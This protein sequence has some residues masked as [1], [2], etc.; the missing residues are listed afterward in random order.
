MSENVSTKKVICFGEVLWDN[1][2]E[3]RRVGGAPLNVCY[4]LNKNGVPSQVV[5]QI[6]DDADGRDLSDAINTLQVDTRFVKSTPHHPTSRVEVH[7]FEDGQVTYDIIEHVAWDYIPYDPEV[8]AAIGQA[9]ALVF[10][11]LAARN[12]I[13]KAT[14]NRYLDGAT[15]AVLD[16]NLRQP[17]YSP[18]LIKDLLS[19][20]HVLKINAE[21]LDALAQWM[22]LEKYDEGDRLTRLLHAYPNIGEIL[23]TKGVRGARYHSRDTQLSVA[24]LKVDS[25]STVG[26]GDSFLAAFLARRMAG[27]P[28]DE[29]MDHAVVL[30]AFVSTHHGACPDYTEALLNAFKQK[31]QP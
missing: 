25:V 12:P 31:N 9:D 13:S 24:A 2:P 21:E 23:L 3:G 27:H 10:G 28:L 22:G 17:F 11:S 15:Y 7:L 20:C 29:A 8:A 1:L 4:H 5:S 16:V 6:G 19:R 30:S 26:T 18:A 14:L